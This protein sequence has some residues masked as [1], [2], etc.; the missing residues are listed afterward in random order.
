M[1]AHEIDAVI[2]GFS[3]DEKSDRFYHEAST[4]FSDSAL[5][6]FKHLSGEFNTSSGFSFFMANHILRNQE[7]PEVMKINKTEKNKINNILIYNQLLGKDH[8]LLLVE[9]I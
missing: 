1:K 8:S 4:L 9:K 5:L 7:I 6:Y 3:G 2:L